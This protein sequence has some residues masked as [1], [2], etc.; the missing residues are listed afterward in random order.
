MKCIVAIT[1]I[2]A[3]VAGACDKNIN[4]KDQSD[5]N[6]INACSKYNADITIDGVKGIT[7]LSLDSVKQVSG[8]LVIQNMYDLQTVS[9]GQLTYAKSLKIVNNTNVY[10][11]D[12]PLLSQIDSDFQVIVNPN[13]KNLQYTNIT[14]VS[15]FQIIDTFVDNLGVFAAS[16]V[17]SIEVLSNPQLKTLDF[18]SV[19]STSGYINIANN[20]KDSNVTFSS[21]TQVGGNISFGNTGALSIDKLNSVGDDFSLYTNSFPNL[22]VSSLQA[23]KKS[24]TLSGNK[25]KTITFPKLTE[26]GSSLNINNNTNFRSIGASTFPQLTSIPGGI[27]LEGNFDNITFPKLKSVDGAVTLKGKGKLTCNT[28][29]TNLSAASN[30]DCSMTNDS[31]EESTDSSSKGSSSSGS[32]SSSKKPSSGA[33]HTTVAAVLGGFAALVAACL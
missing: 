17:G 13:L 19:Q 32:G 12:I 30:I 22:T 2:A 25:F 11:V 23:A 8:Q 21:L 5:I 9:L 18:S 31:T 6:T 7:A 20:A 26:V 24:I 3:L 14:K 16:K 33:S 1:A 28:F 10:K 29:S 15:N 27:I 4:V